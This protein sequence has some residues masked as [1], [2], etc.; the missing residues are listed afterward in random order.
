MNKNIIIGIIVLAILVLA[1][2]WLMGSNKGPESAL[3]T[4]QPQAPSESQPSDTTG[5]II[6]DADA[7]NVGDVD[8]EFQAIDKDLQT[9]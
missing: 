1:G 8:K 2:I 3:P 5:M 9:L 7:L 6:K 4:V